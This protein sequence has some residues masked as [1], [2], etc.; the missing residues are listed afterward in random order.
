M[1]LDV[2]LNKVCLTK[3]RSQA[4]TGCRG[5]HVL[6]AGR[7]VKESHELHGGEIVLL[8]EGDR[9]REVR[10][11]GIPAGNVSRNEARDYYEI[12]AERSVRPEF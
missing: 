3:S 1:R 8:R 5:G 6:L 4:K 10:V 7:P 9:E 2:W 11:L 12:V